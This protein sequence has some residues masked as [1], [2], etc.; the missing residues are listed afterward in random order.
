M[1]FLNIVPAQINCKVKMNADISSYVSRLSTRILLI[2][3]LLFNQVT[4]I[5]KSS[6]RGNLLIQFLAQTEL[7]LASAGNEG[8]DNDNAFSRYDVLATLT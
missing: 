5:F 7:R 8:Q 6:I 4:F 3:F 1:R 2:N